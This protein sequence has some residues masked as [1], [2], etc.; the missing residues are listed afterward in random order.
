MAE[1]LDRDLIASHSLLNFLSAILQGR[2][3]ALNIVNM[4]QPSP[5][6]VELIAHS[7]QNLDQIT[8]W[9]DELWQ[10]KYILSA[11]TAAPK[12]DEATKALGILDD[13][14]TEL[15]RDADRLIEAYSDKELAQNE[16][17]LVVLI[18]QF[19]RYA[20]SMDNHVRGQIDFWLK[21]KQ[22]N[23]AAKLAYPLDR[24]EED[25]RVAN[26]MVEEYR[27][28]PAEVAPAFVDKL[29]ME[30]RFVAGV[31]R[32]QS[33]DIQSILFAGR[34]DVSFTDFGFMQLDQPGW[35][36]AGFSPLASAYWAAYDIAASEAS[37]WKNSG[38]VEPLV[39]AKWRTFGFGPDH[40]PAWIAVSFPPLLAFAWAQAGFDPQTAAKYV[41]QGVLT[42]EQI[43]LKKQDE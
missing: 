28:N 21:N 26:A 11:D 18:S 2:Y 31:L 24:A 15:L 5:A 42:P 33:V 40:G 38:V 35:E 27:G 10:G 43:N 36:S 17:H 34:T 37:A 1:E 23:E 32:A 30:N 19:A 4:L 16:E 39:A 6:T 3:V 12:S 8:K 22:E 41:D 25:V 29:R 9:R 14:R 13:L 20:Y 7:S